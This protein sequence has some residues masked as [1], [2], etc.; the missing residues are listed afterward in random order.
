[1]RTALTALFLLLV[2]F[3][4]AQTCSSGLGD[5]IVN[6]TFGA[7]TNFGPPLAPGIT[8]LEYETLA[9]VLDN[10]YTIVNS[11]S[12]CYVGDWLTVTRDHTGDPNGYYMLIGASHQA[13]DFYVQ[14][15]TGL[16]PSTHYQFAA[17]VLNMASHAGEILPNITFNIEKT[18]GTVL[19]S[20]QT[21]DV[22][23]TNATAWL[24][25]AFNFTTPPGISSVVLRMT[26]NAAGGYGND[27]AIDDITFRAAGPSVN[28]SIN[29]YPGDAVTLCADPAGTLQL[30]GTVGSCYA[31]T[32]YQWQQSSDDGKSWN[33]I[34]GAVSAAYSTSTTHASDLLYRLTA[35]EAGNIGVTTCQVV[36][37]PDSIR[38]LPVAHPALT[39]AADTLTICEGAPVSFSAMPV[40]GGAAPQYQWIVNG[41]PTGDNGPQFNSNV[42]ASGDEVSCLLTSD[43]VCPATATALSNKLIMNVLP[44]ITPSVAIAASANGVCADSLVVFRAT[45]TDGGPHPGYQW[46]VNGDPEGGSSAVFSSNHLHDGDLINVTLTGSLPCSL[47]ATSDAISMS[48]YPLPTVS[49]TP[50]TVIK[51]GTYLQLDP[52]IGGLVAWYVW[53]PSES[54]YSTIIPNP[55]A[56][57]VAS[58]T[59]KLTV[60]TAKGC[61]ASAKEHVTVY[62]DLAMPS[63]F[64]PNGDGHNDLFRI[65]PGISVTNFRLAV[66]DRW[67]GEVFEAVNNNSGW[68][69]T[70]NGTLRPAGTYVWYI[71]YYNPLLKRLEMQ[72]G[73]V[74]LIR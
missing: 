10:A 2:T 16:C 25:Y 48:V 44:N 29:G 33:D 6:I 15:V 57:P 69:G 66:F 19:Q 46:A 13:S 60:T 54:L 23:V 35:A 61:S 62:Y 4:R 70:R 40:D 3:V 20:L 65:P 71:E 7:G 47:P 31:N 22:P 5:P 68:D 32:V 45:P 73:T 49:L 72:K 18:D 27:L 14:T 74:E 37:A 43:A 17:W 67:G 9:C 11:T 39:I 1:M 51:G 41:S 12:N 38:I 55:V 21:G 26:N 53:T 59:Y 30:L 50:D 24:Q 58:T 8:T 36:S 56:N 42:L 34:P 64:T 52:H 63:A 28:I